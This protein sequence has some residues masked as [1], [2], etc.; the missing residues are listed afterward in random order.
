M[1]KRSLSK[2]RSAQR[3]KNGPLVKEVLR[4]LGVQ[5]PAAAGRMPCGVP[6]LTTGNGV[7]NIP[8]GGLPGGLGPIFDASEAAALRDAF[9]TAL[10]V[11]AT[12][13]NCPNPQLLIYIVTNIAPRLPP[14]QIV[15]DVAAI[16]MCVKKKPAR[17]WWDSEGGIKPRTGTTRGRSTKARLPKRATPRR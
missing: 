10:R 3:V 8:A 4:F 2:S 13:P 15:T 17:Q 6:F 7:A 14:P 11:C 12:N 1:P 5:I 16:W 9:A